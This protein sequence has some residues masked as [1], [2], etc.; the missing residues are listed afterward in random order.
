MGEILK[1]IQEINMRQKILQSIIGKKDIESNI[2]RIEKLIFVL[3]EEMDKK[4]V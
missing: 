4:K 1:K 3:A 2:N